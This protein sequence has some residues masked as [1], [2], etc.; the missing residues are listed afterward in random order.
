M[1][2]LVVGATGGIGKHVIKKLLQKD[3][4]ALG[5]IRKEN[6]KET[7]KKLGGIPITG[8]LEKDI[9]DVAKECDAII[10]V[11]GTRDQPKENEY[12]ITVN[13]LKKL[14]DSA[15]RYNVKRFLYVSSLSIDVLQKIFI[16]SL[17]DYYKTN[18][19]LLYAH[20]KTLANSDGYISYLKA[21]KD[22]EQLLINS[23]LNYT[24][25]RACALTNDAGI[26]T[27]SLEK[28]YN[29]MGEISREDVAETF[30]EAL[31]AENLYRQ[32]P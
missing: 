31:D 29:G 27:I 16:N 26:S 15:I 13:G 6:Q 1:K 23:G 25:I 12:P 11:F 18:P 21:K 9:S 4:I 20:I 7:I 17:D 32:R 2:I 24:I 28:N 8:D 10:A 5:M 3:H 14:I 19:S 30:V 22:A